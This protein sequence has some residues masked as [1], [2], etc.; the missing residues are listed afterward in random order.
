MLAISIR[1]RFAARLFSLSNL[2]VHSHYAV[3]HFLRKKKKTRA[4]GKKIAWTLQ[5][6]VAGPD[7]R[8]PL[9]RRRHTCLAW[10]YR[11][12]KRV[13]KRKQWCAFLVDCKNRSVELNKK[14]FSVTRGASVKKEINS[15]H[16]QEREREREKPG[17][18]LHTYTKGDVMFENVV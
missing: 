3:R 7:W 15:A 12:C 6:I 18:W 13:E 8:S 1:G 11:G 16:T 9:T 2:H 5:S 17:L 14:T 10:S 4:P